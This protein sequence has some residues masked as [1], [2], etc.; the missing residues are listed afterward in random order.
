MNLR[1]WVLLS[2]L[3]ACPA[4]A[5]DVAVA[6]G[7]TLRGL[8]KVSG[9]LTDIEIASGETKAF[10]RLS[11]TM[12]ECRYPADDPSSNA[13]AHL[14]MT[15]TTV[16]AVIFDGWMIAGSPALSALDHARYDVWLLRCNIE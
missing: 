12:T 2:V 8:D 7:A 14:A 11:I 1:S 15:D 5:Q 10:E 6:P 3:A 9:A 4:A 13:F 16:N